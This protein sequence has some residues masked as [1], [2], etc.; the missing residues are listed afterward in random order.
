[1]SDEGGKRQ[2]TESSDYSANDSD[3]F[4][5]IGVRYLIQNGSG[6]DR[7]LLAYNGYFLPIVSILFWTLFLVIR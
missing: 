2:K 7:L 4:Q 6:F 1:M 5:P 3:L